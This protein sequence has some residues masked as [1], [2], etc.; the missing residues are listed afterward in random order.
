MATG[1]LLS[2]S[3]IVTLLGESDRI[4]VVGPVHHLH[5]IPRAPGSSLGSTFLFCADGERASSGE[6]ETAGV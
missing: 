6:G 3:G 1:A 4:D 2:G 5:R